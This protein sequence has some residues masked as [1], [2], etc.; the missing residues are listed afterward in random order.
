MNRRTRRAAAIAREHFG[1]EGDAIALPG[2]FDLNFRL[3]GSG[4]DPATLRSASPEEAG[5][6]PRHDF[7]L[8]LSPT[9]R[10]AVFDLVTKSLQHIDGASLPASV[11]RVVQPVASGHQG[12][13]VPIG[14]FEG[15][16]H[17]ACALT[18][19]AGR[20]FADVR[21]RSLPALEELGAFLARLDLALSGFDHPEL[22]R[23]FA[24]RMESASGTI[25]SHLHMLRDG[26]P[27]V[28]GT[29]HRATGL[30][31]PLRDALPRSVIHNDA[32]DYNVMVSP[33]LDGTRL[34]GLID[35]G[36][37]TRG[38]RAAEVA[39]AAAY[40]MMELHDPVAAACAVARGYSRVAPL[41]EAEC[42]AIIPMVAL[43]LCLSVSVQARQMREQPDNEYLAV[44]Q[45][46]A[47]R[48]LGQL[49]DADWRVA[50]SR[51]R[52]ACGLVP[53]PR[54]APVLGCLED[55]RPR[56]RVMASEQLE[57]PCLIDL[58]VES[59]D[60]PHLDS[61]ATDGVLDAWVEDTIAA[62]DAT[63][64]VGRYG[65]ARILYDDPAFAVR[66][67][68]GPES[69]TI[70]LGLDLFAPP[71]TPVQAPLA[72]TVASVADNAGPRDY[73]PTVILRH[74]TAE[75]FGFH[76]LYGHL[77][78]A[79][80]EH[81]TPGAT[82]AAGEVLGWLGDASVN[83]GWPPHLHLQVIALDPLYDERAAT[84]APGDFPGVAQQ[85]LRP[86]WESILPD[87]T[88]LAGLP[89]TAAPSATAPSAAAAQGPLAGAPTAVPVPPIPDPVLRFADL[90]A[91]RKT[92][93]GSSL[94]LSYARPVHIVRGHGAWLYDDTG[95]RYLDTVNN[96]SHV[97]HA[98][99]RV[100]EAIARHTRV[101]NTNTRYLHTQ[102]VALAEELLEHFPSPLEV[103]FL[104]CSGSEANELALRMARCHTGANGVVCLEGGYHGNTGAVV[105]I[106]QYK[107]AGP[108]G[109][110]PSDRV[111]VASMPD[112]Y[113]GRYRGPDS[114]ALYAEDVA[115]AASRLARE[116]G[117]PGVAAF[118]A[119]PILSCGGQIEPPPG[120]LE[121][122]FGHVRRDGGV[123][124][125]DE[126]QVGFGRV[127][128]A[129][130][131]FELQGVVPDIVTLGKPMGNGHPVAAVVTTREIADSFANG[132]EYFSTFGGNPVSCAAARAV[133]AEIRSRGLRERAGRVGGFL[134]RSLAELARRHPIVGDVRGR[135]LF[136]GMEVVRDPETRDPYPEACTYIANRARDLGVFLSVDGP[137]HNVLKFKPPLVFGETEAELLIATLEAVLGETAL[138]V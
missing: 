87:P 58:S 13:V 55:A 35:F 78:K 127:G 91:K 46:P 66:G 69:R 10:H 43:R 20:P 131:A 70:H 15:A 89:S 134:L 132:M 108:G 73:G 68:H 18:W 50:E 38:W 41:G 52:E 39:V 120:Y 133:L 109:A 32:N 82:V 12:P 3:S 137:D 80:L 125:A 93:L 42:R 100:A 114:A 98:N 16:P 27:L 9:S 112:T 23:G 4:P 28:E 30:L 51:I 105:E 113:R 83:G 5:R 101:L 74:E 54:L 126:V 128:D 33:S 96:V 36:D 92:F 79:T 47:W 117:G 60:L 75:G 118:V 110:G 53:N 95:R 29:L 57:R 129:F 84:P 104:V 19:V 76:T 67:D 31:D 48:L 1:I 64:G 97:G 138:A 24:W 115:E 119:E 85:R 116:S 122:A 124:I 61:L 2:E 99:R 130:W 40:G 7:V 103:V 26:R 25:A 34:S 65:E 86:V 102:I 123:C 111:A 106:S 22:G 135:G 63:V 21:P 17:L 49:A 90:T 45:K 14:G 56:S 72:G 44:S 121:A 71:G 107:F 6:A 11:P 136:L 59:L 94:S 88:P 81:L 62:A 37:L 77:D 8:K